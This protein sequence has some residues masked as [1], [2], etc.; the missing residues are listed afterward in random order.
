MGMAVG[1]YLNNGQLDLYNTV[2]SDDYNPLYRNDGGGNFT[3][4]SY[5]AGIAEVTIP[6][7]GMGHGLPRFRQRRLERPLLWRMDMC[8]RASTKAIGV[9][10][11]PSGL[12]CSAICITGNSMWFRPVKGTGLALLLT[13]QRR[14]F[15][16]SLQRRKDRC[17]D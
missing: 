11:L 17:G 13:A 15:R 14:S 8:I 2:F 5:Q 4:V 12:F 6:F 16:R 1:D 10:R 3:D 7:L 9:R